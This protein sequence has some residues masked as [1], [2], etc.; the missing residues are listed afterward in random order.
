MAWGGL[1][2]AAALRLVDAALSL[3]DGGALAPLASALREAA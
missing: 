1:S 2:D 3:A